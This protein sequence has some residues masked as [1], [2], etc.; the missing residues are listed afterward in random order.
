ML[1]ACSGGI[2]CTALLGHYAAIGENKVN[3]L[4]LLVSVLDTT[5][6]TDVACSSTSRPSKPPSATPTRPAC[7]K[8]ATWP[9]CS[10]GCAPTT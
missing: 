8:A 7:W 6:D 5:L 9:R 1:G 3:A 10:P 2:T 4:T